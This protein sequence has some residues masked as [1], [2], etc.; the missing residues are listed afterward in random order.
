[1]QNMV[2]TLDTHVPVN[3]SKCPLMFLMDKWT[4]RGHYF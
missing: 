3:F 2:N 1:M 4:P